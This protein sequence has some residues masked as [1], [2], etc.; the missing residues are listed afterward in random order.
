MTVIDEA[1]SSQQPGL[2]PT[3]VW[4]KTPHVYECVRLLPLEKKPYPDFVSATCWGLWA[5]VLAVQL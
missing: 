5:L 1:I 3:T 2:V 4:L